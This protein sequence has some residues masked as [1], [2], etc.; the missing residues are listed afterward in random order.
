MT[1][2]SQPIR[3]RHRGGS[4]PV[5]VGPGLF[6]SLTTELSR[7][8]AGR[9]IAVI[10]DKNV[11]RAVPLDLRSEKLVV[12]PGEGSKSR[13]RWATLT[14][15]LV[16]LGFGRDSMIVAVGGGVVG[17]LA[18]FVAATYLRGIPYVQVPTSLVAMVDSAVGGKTGVNTPAGKNL[19]GAFHPPVAVYAD[20]N[21]LT[22]LPGRFF[23]EGLVEALKHGV[24]ADPSY[25]EWI[26]ANADALR[27]RDPAALTTLVRRSVRIKAAIVSQD[28]HEAGRRAILNAGHTIGHAVESVSR[29][30]VRHGLAVAIGL[31]LETEM[32]E[33][34]GMAPAGTAARI[35]A[36]YRALD[37]KLRIPEELPSCPLRA[38]IGRDKKAA[39][40][41][42][43][44]ALPAGIG[45]V[46]RDGARWTVEVPDGAVTRA[47]GRLREF[48]QEPT[49]GRSPRVIHTR[50][51]P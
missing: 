17:D 51:L 1:P 46:A 15:R 42:T 47:L 4:Y 43:R 12:A 45:R 2:G 36:L 39:A 49:Q 6:G 48:N 27:A 21:V 28:E 3:V 30:R 41:V 14:N 8:A 44:F 23:R 26:E 38:A 24:V 22:A 9:R 16:A 40:G 35:E 11:A 32:S 20:P 33:A 29:F 34:L 25:F 37:I 31:L 10:T 5:M 18:G 13:V 50:R 7:L 19:V